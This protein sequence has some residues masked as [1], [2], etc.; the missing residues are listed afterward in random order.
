MLPNV[1]PSKF[2]NSI[3]LPD[4][5]HDAKNLEVSISGEIPDKSTIMSLPTYLF[6]TKLFP[7]ISAPLTYSS[8]GNYISMVVPSFLVNVIILP[9]IVTLLIKSELLSLK[10]FN[11]VIKTHVATILSFSL[12][13][14]S[15]IGPISCNRPYSQQQLLII[16]YLDLRV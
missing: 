12:R 8:I 3:V 10:Y 6:N 15:I 1:S 2:L 11:K 5:E 4:N 16:S 14:P 13:R 7:D 9:F